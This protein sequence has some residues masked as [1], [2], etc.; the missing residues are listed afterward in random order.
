MERE[1]ILMGL[2]CANCALKMEKGIKAIPGVAAATVS[3]GT[4]VLNI[5]IEQGLPE[6]IIEQAQKI[7]EKIEP[8]VIIKEKRGKYQDKEQNKAGKYK[9]WRLALGMGLFL[10][11]LFTAKSFSWQL[12]FYAAAYFLI[13]GNIILTAARNIAGGQVFDENFLMVLATLGAF[14][15][16]EYPEAV[17]VMIFYQIGEM[18]QDLAVQRSRRSIQD[19]LDIRP[20]YANLKKGQ[21]YVQVDPEEVTVGEIIMVRVGER[22]PLDGEVME[23]NSLVDTSALT[24]EAVPRRV[25]PG[26]GVLSGFINTNAILHIKVAKEYSQSTV[27]KILDMVQYAVN[28]KARVENFIT[29]FAQY[30]TPAVVLTAAALAIIP[31]LA[32]P[33]ASFSTWFYRALIFLVI[34]CPCALVISIPL[35]FFGGIGA[36]SKNG[37]LVKG[38]NYLEALNSVDTVVFDKTGTLTRGVFQVT[39]L[40][41]A[42]GFK[43]DG[44]LEMAALAESYSNHP[45]AR[46]IQGAWSRPL[47]KEGID[48]YEEMAGL[49]VRI[50]YRGKTILA[51]RE[52]FLQEAGVSV[53]GYDGHGTIVHVAIEGKYAGYLVISD[54]LKRDSSQALK[55]LKEMGVKKLVMLTGDKEETA[56]ALGRDLLFDQI[57]GELLP[58]DKVQI[59]GELVEIERR[60]NLVYVGDGINDAPV[61]ARADIG[62]AMGA[63]GSDAA[64]EAADVVLMTDEPSKLVTAIK[65]SRE[66]HRIVWQNIALALVVK[67]V[68]LLMGAGGLATMWEAVFADVGVAL[69]AVLNAMGIMRKSYA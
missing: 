47:D 63:L 9:I 62:V 28:K 54:E 3:F 21:E 24:G 61:L 51:G 7:V 53:A 34:S 13:G 68:V 5:E 60:G 52:I 22:I 17:A 38:G 27:A 20:E 11:A 32:L 33:G 14:A 45:I 65:I 50:L 18:F 16:G 56:L 6:D 57:Y 4:G 36:A 39:A 59:V 37:I 43:Q 23:G 2:G 15:I 69:L 30:Y 8:G 1:Y 35:S 66:T 46:S 64:I 42:P 49:G 67:G 12:G 19:L 10:G 40:I 29:R 41:P 48:S 58:Q 26:D 25:G 44:L 31:P 55:D